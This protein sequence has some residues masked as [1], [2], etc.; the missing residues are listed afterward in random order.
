MVLLLARVGPC[1]ATGSPNPSAQPRGAHDEMQWSA[2]EWLDGMQCSGVEC[3]GCILAILGHF[4]TFGHFGF[5]FG[6]FGS[7]T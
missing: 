2:M 4:D 5:K 1:S 6:R 3:N 7:K